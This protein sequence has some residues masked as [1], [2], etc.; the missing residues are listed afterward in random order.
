[1]I[2]KNKNSNFLKSLKD[3][4]IKYKNRINNL[5]DITIIEDDQLKLLKTKLHKGK[6]NLNCFLKKISSTE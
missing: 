1:M 4:R 6:K 2:D 5:L 3:L